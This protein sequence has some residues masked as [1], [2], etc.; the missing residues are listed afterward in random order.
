[1]R[2]TAPVWVLLLAAV[3]VLLAKVVVDYDHSVDFSRYHTY[4]WIKAEAENPLWT[5][6][7]SN[8]VDSQLSAK[9]WQKVP[10]DGDA[11]VAAF[12]TTKTERT[13]QTWYD[14]FGGG[15]GWH[16]WGGPGF[17]TTTVEK[18]PVGTLTVDIFDTPTKKLIWRATSERTLSDNPEKNEKKL[19]DDVA[20]M[21]KKFPPKA[22][23]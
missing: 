6:R 21:F 11:S 12:G 20:E 14:G 22:K 3:S 2:K 17:A 1:M 15:W 23:G 16:G 8:A 19:Q 13:L 10:A 5:D 18:V 9:G 4:S 7:I